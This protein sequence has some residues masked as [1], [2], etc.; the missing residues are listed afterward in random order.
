MKSPALVSMVPRIL[1]MVA[2]S[3]LNLRVRDSFLWG[4]LWK[5]LK[6]QGFELTHWCR[7]PLSRREMALLGYSATCGESAFRCHITMVM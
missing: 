3:F 6:S 4:L 1:G 2:A 5:M 7:L